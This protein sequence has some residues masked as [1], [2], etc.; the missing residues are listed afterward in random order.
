MAPLALVG[1]YELLMLLI[2]S[3]QQ[4]HAEKSVGTTP[5]HPAPPLAQ[6]DPPVV[7]P[8]P[9]IEQTVR[10][11]HSAGRSQRAIAREL[12]IDRRKVKQIIER[13]A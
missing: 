13:A 2:R 4:Q 7:P 12:N 10:A 6:A 8:T 3:S 11:W 5:I 1:S 9:S